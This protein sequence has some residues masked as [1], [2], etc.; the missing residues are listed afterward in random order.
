VAQAFELA[1]LVQDVAVDS[2]DWHNVCAE[3]ALIV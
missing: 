3:V 2:D 1:F